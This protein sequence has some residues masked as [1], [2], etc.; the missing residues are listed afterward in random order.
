MIAKPLDEVWTCWTDPGHIM[1]WNAASDDWHCPHAEN[2]LRVGGRFTS[3][4]ESRDGSFGFDFRG[5]YTAVEP[6][7]RLAYTMEDG[8]ICSVQFDADAQGTRVAETFDAENENPVDMQRN[9]W[10][11]ILDRFKQYVEKRV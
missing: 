8:R 11:A 7:S 5:T 1:Q 4:M 2:D 6:R 9:G 3:R 10:Q